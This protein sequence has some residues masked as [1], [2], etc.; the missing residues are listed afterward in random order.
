MLYFRYLLPV[1][2]LHIAHDLKYGEIGCINNN[3]YF[4]SSVNTSYCS[5]ITSEDKSVLDILTPFSF[6]RSRIRW[7]L[8]ASYYTVAAVAGLYVLHSIACNSN[9]EHV[10]CLPGF[11]CE[12]AC[13]LLWMRKRQVYAVLECNLQ[14]C[15]CSLCC[16]HCTAQLLKH[17]NMCMCIH[18]SYSYSQLCT[19][20]WLV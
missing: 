3:Q 2:S 20:V 1:M 17:I 15:C 10:T 11:Y 14:G 5:D 8:R 16:V 9:L 6:F 12:N 18:E 4:N 7:F 13:L 19:M